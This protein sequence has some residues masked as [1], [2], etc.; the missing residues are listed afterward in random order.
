LNVSSSWGPRHAAIQPSRMFEVQHRSGGD[1]AV[2]SFHA[3]RQSCQST[4]WGAA[5]REKSDSNTN[6]LIPHPN[7]QFQGM[8][9]ATQTICLRLIRLP[10]YPP[11]CWQRFLFGTPRTSRSALYLCHNTLRR[12]SGILWNP[13]TSPIVLLHIFICNR[14]RQMHSDAFRC[15]QMH[16]NA[17]RSHL[18]VPASRTSTPPKPSSENV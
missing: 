12:S 14:Y 11:D 18:L 2:H 15:L 7:G 3:V 16:S 6:R 9:D 13:P 5:W 17:F 8:V 10:A 1:H 4:I